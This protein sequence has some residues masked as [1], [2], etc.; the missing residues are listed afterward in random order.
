MTAGGTG[1]DTMLALGYAADH[2]KR[3]RFGSLVSPVSY[4]HPVILTRQ[5]IQLDHLSNGRM[6][7]GVGSGWVEQEHTMFSFDLGDLATR[8]DRL[9]EAL[10]VITLLL[11]SDDPV[12]YAGRFYQLQ[13]ALLYPRPLHAHSP[14]IL[15]GA[16]GP[17]RTLP[18]VA[19][20]ADI[21][22]G[23]GLTVEEFQNNSQ[24]LDDLLHKVGRQPTDVKR[25]V[26]LPVLCG[27]TDD[28]F[29]QQIRGLRLLMTDL[30]TNPWQS[31]WEVLSE[32]FPTMIA[33]DPETVITKL[34]AYADAG[35]EELIIAWRGLDNYEGLERIATDIVS[36]FAAQRT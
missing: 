6:I 32:G 35:V 1:L 4:R 14:R 9:E 8:I 29:Q 20:Y 36:Q 3:I 31:V 12:N 7:L 18:L 15:L 27:R 17:R 26:Y 19:R 5:A 28:E 16:K 2:T 34:Q 33:G 13:D 10:Q 30:P 11:R 25:T 22:N 21:W 24:L 23:E